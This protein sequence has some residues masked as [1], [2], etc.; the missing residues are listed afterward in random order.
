MADRARDLLL[1]PI[2]ERNPIALLVL[3]ICSALAVTS[4]MRTALVMSVCVA[5][6]TACSSLVI[7]LVRA[8]IPNSVRIGL[9]ITVIATLVILVDQVLKTFFFDLAKQLSVYVGLIITNCIVMGRAEGFAMANPPG[10][11][12][13]DGIGN[14]LG[15]ASILMS[16]AFVRELLGSGRLF[17]FE[18][19]PL[20]TTG[21][22][23]VRNGLLLMP[24]SAFFLIALIIW[25]L[26]TIDPAQQEK[27]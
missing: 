23:Y 11:S 9:Q 14:G 18:I 6:V 1:R 25:L 16:V 3:G 10:K 19:L 12:F 20:T 4:Q 13:L 7:S 21:G 15:Y 22:W 5:L 27:P 24:A 8:R 2:I 26:R 17:G